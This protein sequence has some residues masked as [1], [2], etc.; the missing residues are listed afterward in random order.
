[1]PPPVLAPQARAFLEAIGPRGD[2]F[3]RPIAELRAEA[4]EIARRFSGPAEPVGSIEDIDAGG[5]PARLYA[6][7]GHESDVLVW[8]HGGAWMLGGLDDHDALSCA[9]VNRTG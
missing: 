2:E 1:M 7:T 5:V 8:F 6:Q 4:A 3:D 9:L